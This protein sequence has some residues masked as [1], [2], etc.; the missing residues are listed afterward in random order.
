MGAAV[1]ITRLDLT[2]GELRKA[3]RR[4]KNSTV[5]RRIL[6][7]ALVLEGA[8]RKK[9]AESCGMDRQTLRD[10]VHRYN[11]EGLAG[12]RSRK[13][14][15]PRSRLTTEQQAELAALVEAGPDP[16]QHG[17]VRWRRVDLR[18]ALERRFGVKLHER[19]VGK[20]LA[21]LGYRRLS[22]RPR[23][24]QAD[25]AAQE[26]FSK[27]FATTL[28]TTLPAHAQGKPIEIWFQDEARIGQQGTLTRV[29][30]K[31]GSRPRAPRDRRYDWAYLFGAACPQRGVA[32]GLVMPTANAEAMSLHLEAISRKVAPDAHAVLVF[33][34]A[35]YH[36]AGTV[37]APENITLL[38]LPPY[39]P[40][41]NPIENVWQYL[42]ANKLA[43]TVFDD[44]DDIVAKTCEAWNFFANDPDR[45]ASITS[46][47]WAT[48][49]P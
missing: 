20:V 15:G 36:S 45:I 23:H 12:L 42:R 11:A 38:Q 31:R 8:D 48:V 47:T 14:T 22:V 40:E 21:K 32:A 43:I 24:P 19:S 25:E 18:D 49:N 2:A 39:A 17:V 4:E 10:W 6:A 13:P 5:A 3:A 26:A 29:W 16:E 37:R 41:L 46:R 44:Y 9:A 28:T 7:L 30:A 27:N 34:G 35:G 33:D 1:A